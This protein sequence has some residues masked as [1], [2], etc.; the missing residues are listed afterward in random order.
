[1]EVDN[2]KASVL[3]DGLARAYDKDLDIPTYLFQRG[4]DRN[5]DKEHPLVPGVPVSLGKTA[6][7]ITPIQLPISSSIPELRDTHRNI[8]EAQAQVTI[9]KA[10]EHS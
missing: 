7:S 4:D 2:G 5:P 6:V 10:K 8:I 9:N 1:M 3:T